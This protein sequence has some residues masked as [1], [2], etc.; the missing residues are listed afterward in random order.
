MHV[1]PLT[2]ELAQRSLRVIPVFKRDPEEYTVSFM[3]LL[4]GKPRHYS[5]SVGR[6]VEIADEIS[7]PTEIVIGYSESDPLAVEA[8]N[9][10]RK[11]YPEVRIVSLSGNVIGTNKREISKRCYGKFLAIFDLDYIYDYSHADIVFKFVNFAEKRMLFSEMP[12]IPSSLL[13]EAGNWR[14]LTAGEDVDLYS[15]IAILSGITAYP[16]SE[17]EDFEYMG[18]GVPV[19]DRSVLKRIQR[20]FVTIRDL[21]IGCNYGVRDMMMFNSEKGVMRSALLWTFFSACLVGSKFSR[22][23]TLKYDRSNY[24]IFM[25]NVMES[26]V[27][28]DFLR[29]DRPE[30][31]ISLGLTGNEVKYLQKKSKTWGQIKDTL[32]RHIRVEN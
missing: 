8:V 11:A 24:L 21:M 28:K 19:A 26:I 27:I 5:K 25:E 15:R 17:L 12:V 22:V 6:I 3:S 2:E 4:T 31:R 32:S 23:R 14:D 9:E 29:F 30:D 18:P 16:R 20:N 10:I 13:S 1:Y 7:V